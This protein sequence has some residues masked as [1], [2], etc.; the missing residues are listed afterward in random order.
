[1]PAESGRDAAPVWC[2]ET[3]TSVNATGAQT[4]RGDSDTD[5]A[6]RTPPAVVTVAGSEEAPPAAPLAPT[7]VASGN[8]TDRIT[9]GGNAGRDAVPCSEAWAG[10]PGNHSAAVATESAAAARTVVRSRRWVIGAWACGIGKLPVL[11]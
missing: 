8:G 10:P 1:M 6:T 11:V 4:T 9:V 2:H 3:P 5:R 7:I